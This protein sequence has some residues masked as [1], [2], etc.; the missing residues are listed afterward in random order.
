M[1]V[2]IGDSEPTSQARATSVLAGVSQLSSQVLSVQQLADARSGVVRAAARA[3][4]R[5]DGRRIDATTI[6]VEAALVRSRLSLIQRNLLSI[7]PTWLAG[8]FGRALTGGLIQDLMPARAAVLRQ[9][10]I[11]PPRVTEAICLRLGGVGQRGRTMDAS[12]TLEVMLEIDADDTLKVLRRSAQAGG[13]IEA[14]YLLLP[15]TSKA[16]WLAAVPGE[17]G[18]GRCLQPVSPFVL[19]I[20]DLRSDPDIMELEANAA[21]QPH[22]I[23]GTRAVSCQLPFGLPSIANDHQL[24]DML[25]VS[26]EVSPDG[27]PDRVR[28]T[29]TVHPQIAKYQLGDRLRLTRAEIRFP[30]SYPPIRG[31]RMIDR[32]R[33]RSDTTSVPDIGSTAT[34]N[35]T[36]GL[37]LAPGESATIEIQ[38]HVERGSAERG[39]TAELELQ[40]SYDTPIGLPD[41]VILAHPGGCARE[42]LA[43][44][45]GHLTISAHADVDLSRLKFRDHARKADAIEADTSYVPS[46]FD[47]LRLTSLLGDEHIIIRQILQALPPGYPEPGGFACDL[48][49]RDETNLNGADVHIRVIREASATRAE[50]PPVRFEMTVMARI[51]SDADPNY[52]ARLS[53]K[54]RGCLR[55]LIG[56]E[57]SHATLSDTAFPKTG[58]TTEAAADSDSSQRPSG[59]EDRME[60]LLRRLERGLDRLTELVEATQAKART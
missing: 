36:D 39:G 42:P 30:D 34:M 15:P 50:P 32:A 46:M 4:S 26:P 56:T 60:M 1:Q 44:E 13:S 2:S 58:E 18:P 41:H 22:D 38:F 59:V 10:P 23:A 54:L 43:I 24:A 8:F 49:G 53:D 35:L 40:F 55:E 7:L 47:V 51:A 37:P 27:E 45:K 20:G 11:R 57:A 28:M 9:G 16:N 31:I 17:S 5:R 33:R 3:A 12:G 6:A 19:R 52:L 48:F 29:V 14:G 25:I 21:T